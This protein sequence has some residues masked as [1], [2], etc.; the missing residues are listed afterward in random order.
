MPTISEVNHFS[1]YTTAKRRTHQVLGKNAKLYLSNRK[2]K[3]FMVIDP[4]THKKINFGQM[5]YED[6]LKHKDKT[7]RRHFLTR[8]HKWKSAKKYSPAYL[9]YHILW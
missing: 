9:A 4:K 1:N 6:W 2:N 8:N 5:G 7:R 3:K